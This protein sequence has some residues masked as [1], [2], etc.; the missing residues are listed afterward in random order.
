MFRDRD[1]IIIIIV[2]ITTCIENRRVVITNEAR[3]WTIVDGVSC[4]LRINIYIYMVD[5][6]DT[7]GHERNCIE[8]RGIDRRPISFPPFFFSF[9]PFSPRAPFQPP[10][11]APHLVSP[12]R[13]P[14]FF[15]FP[16]AADTHALPPPSLPPPLTFFSLFS[17]SLSPSFFRPAFFSSFACNLASMMMSR[18]KERRSV[19]RAVCTFWIKSNTKSA[20]TDD[21][22]DDARLF[23]RTGI[24]GVIDRV[25][26][27]LI[28]CCSV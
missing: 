12:F 10:S 6:G 11:H 16:V 1:I 8:A 2:V 17:F 7:T 27:F 22:H 13:P 25:L 26:I 4:K 9:S 15:F 19:N 5:H 24:G 3:E 18:K 14:L 28:I 23:V 20:F 21:L